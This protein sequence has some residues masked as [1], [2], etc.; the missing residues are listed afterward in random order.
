MLMN[1]GSKG[2]RIALGNMQNAI[3][4]AAKLASLKLT[5]R[6]ILHL[7]EPLLD[8]AMQA[9]VIPDLWTDVGAFDLCD[10]AMASHARGLL[11]LSMVKAVQ[12]ANG[13]LI[14][15][16]SGPRALTDEQ[17]EK[18]GEALAITICA[19]GF[20]VCFVL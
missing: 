3:R 9:G 13:C 8:D 14:E 16:G 11:R 5:S 12:S 2:Q 10:I 15:N 19:G 7:S 1:I 18:L 4:G 20:K 17:C 6:Q